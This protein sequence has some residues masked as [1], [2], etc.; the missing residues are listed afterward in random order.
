MT[1]LILVFQGEFRVRTLA[2]PIELDPLTNS[3]LAFVLLIEK[4]VL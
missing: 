3:K 4:N 1:F 2:F